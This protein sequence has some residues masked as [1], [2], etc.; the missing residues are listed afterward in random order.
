MPR[1]TCWP[2]EEHDATT[3]RASDGRTRRRRPALLARPACAWPTV[4]DALADRLAELDPDGAGDLPPRTPLPCGPTSRR[5]TPSCRPRS[6]TAAVDTLVTAHDA[7]GYLADRYGLDVVGISG[8]S[9]SQEPVAGA[10]RRRSPDLVDERGVTT[11][12]T[13]TLVDPAVAETVAV[14]GR[15]CA[16]P[17]S[18]RSR[19]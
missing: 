8:L 5:S 15:A 12:Y 13:E 2:G 18:T 11:V 19:G 1:P 9:P 10:A 4:G 7:F 6:P 17:S 16:P 14:R 3:T